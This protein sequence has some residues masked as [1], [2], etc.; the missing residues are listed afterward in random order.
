MNLTPLSVPPDPRCPD[1]G[2]K[3]GRWKQTCDELVT[4]LDEYSVTLL[5]NA[6]KF[7]WFGDSQGADIVQNSCVSCLA[8]LALL[9]DL[10][11]RSEPSSKPQMDTLCDSS[12]ERLGYLTQEMILDEYTYL[13]HLLRARCFVPNSRQ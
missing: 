3:L 2:T 11:S 8:H 13:D 4:R 10:V 5:R 1:T 12:L 6:R 9:C 7:L